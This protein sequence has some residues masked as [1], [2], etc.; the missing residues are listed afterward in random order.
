MCRTPTSGRMPRARQGPLLVLHRFNARGDGSISS[1]TKTV[2]HVTFLRLSGIRTGSTMH[3][4][5]ASI[6]AYAVLIRACARL[7]TECRRWVELFALGSRS[8]AAK[9][10]PRRPEKGDAKGRSKGA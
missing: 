5:P 8:R 4:D 1:H 6:V 10:P 2:F 3:S 7:G 9:N